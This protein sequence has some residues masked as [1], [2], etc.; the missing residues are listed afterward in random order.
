MIKLEDISGKLYE[1]EKLGGLR[2]LTLHVLSKGPKNGVEI[3]DSIEKHH[4]MIREMTHNNYDKRLD[5]ALRPSSGAIYPLLKKLEAEGL[6]LKRD[7]GKY[8]LTETGFETIRKLMGSLWYSLDKPVERGE[9]VI[10][11]ALNEIDSYIS[12]LADFKKEKLQSKKEN[13]R[14]LIERLTE[15][16]DSIK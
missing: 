7:D 1:L 3:M 13:I 11:A 10:D 9:I 14:I 16:E 4:E 15:L 8:G 2:V 12:L 6:V 5:K